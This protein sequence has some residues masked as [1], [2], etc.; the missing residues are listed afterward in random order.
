LVE[1]AVP[2]WNR[3]LYFWFQIRDGGVYADDGSPKLGLAIS[4]AIEI[5]GGSQMLCR[6]L[7]LALMGLLFHAQ[8][9]FASHRACYSP[10]QA[11]EHVDQDICLAVHIYRVE[12]ASDGTR[13]L[14]VCGNSVAAADEATVPHLAGSTSCSLLVMSLAQDRHEVG[15]LENVTNK[16][17]QVRGTVHSMQGQTVLLV[18]HARQFH[19]GPE[20]FRPNPE[21]LRGFTAD[22]A[23]T[24]F[25]DPGMSPHGKHAQSSAFGGRLTPVH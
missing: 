1:G 9:C 11:S 15:T 2:N 12:E 10:T 25:R 3:L 5:A 13:I 7:T 8:W 18:S 22:E 6:M 21:L 19:D 23:A 20:K 14:D 16:D 17:V 4:V 24:A